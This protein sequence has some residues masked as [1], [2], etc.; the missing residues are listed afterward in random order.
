MSRKHKEPAEVPQVNQEKRPEP[1]SAQSI[2]VVESLNELKELFVQAFEHEQSKKILIETI[3]KLTSQIDERKQQH[4][5]DQLIIDIL[6]NTLKTEPKL[7]RFKK[8]L[9]R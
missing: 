9:T 8:W 7:T 6:L 2:S 3:E 1:L 5:T 4:E